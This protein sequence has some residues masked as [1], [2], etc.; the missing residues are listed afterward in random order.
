M[1]IVITTGRWK[2]DPASRSLV[3]YLRDH[4]AELDLT[5]A[6]IYYD[7]PAYADYETVLIRPDILVFSPKHGFF[8]IRYFE[9]TLF[10]RSGESASDIDLA[11]GDFTSNLYSRLLRSREL[12][13]TRT[14]TKIDIFPVIF[15]PI[16]NNNSRLDDDKIESE[17]CRS[18]EAV[19]QY[20][21]SKARDPLPDEIVAEVRSVVEGAKALS[22]PQKRTIEDLVGKP[23]A[24][25]MSTLEGE[26]ANFDEKQRH[27]ALVD[28]G[29]PARIRGLAGSGKTVIL[30]MKA[31]HLHLNNPE[32]LIL[33]TFYTKSLRATIKSM[34]TKFYRHYSETDPD[35]KRLHIR[36]GWGG[37]SVPGVYSDACRRLNRAPLNLSEA[38]R[39]AG[40]GEPPFGAACNQLNETEKVAAYYDHV[41]I[42]EG[43]DFPDGF[44]RLCLNLAKG[45][46]DK[47]SI[48]W[49]Y[50][51]LQDIMNVK[52]RQ[53]DELFGR[54]DF[55]NPHVDLDRSSVHLPPGSTNDAVLS[56]AYRNQRDILVSAHA[57]GFG[58]YGTI[59]QMLE[60]AEHWEDVGYEV[61][62]GPLKTGQPVHILRPDKNSPIHVPVVDG[63]PLL[64][65]ESARDFDGEVDWITTSIKNFIAA[66]LAPEEI[67]VISLDDRN[68]KSYLSK[69]AEKLSLLGIASN[70]VIADPYN[71]PP[72]TLAGKV[73]LSTVYRAKGNEAAAVFAAGIDA[74]ETKSRSGRNKIFTA[75]TRSKAWLRV[76]GIGRSA[77]DILAEVKIASDYAPEMKFIMPDLREIET[78]QRGFSKKQAAARAAR[79]QYVKKLKAAGFSDEEIEEEFQQVINGH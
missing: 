64:Q 22:R 34:I 14:Q 23:L 77:A 18:L 48:V 20:L 45:E 54:D 27:I 71:E 67:L 4:Q 21:L 8:A 6:T 43:Q 74:V 39:L 73:S 33:F 2:N 31:A 61:L 46:R 76:S 70:N 25:A 65:W 24:V 29:G 55:G 40:R 41:L 79:E 5:E 69:I 72:F 66:G 53:P 11:L 10:K 19:A 32:A 51:E 78:I 68:A 49:A 59:V 60:S 37:S 9:N 1:E 15:A 42:D 62:S 52:I 26:I 30:A 38:S 58:V 17:V 47:K 36:H 13:L 7:F 75:F 12:R 44:Y 16:S 35:W 63:F 50:D 28:V 57:M 3:E 56:K